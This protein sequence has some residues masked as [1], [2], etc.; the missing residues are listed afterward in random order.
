MLN[1]TQSINGPFIV[2]SLCSWEVGYG[3]SDVVSMFIRHFQRQ[4]ARLKELEG[5]L[6]I[7][8]RIPVHYYGAA[9]C[10]CG[11]ANNID[12]RGRVGS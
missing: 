10:A 4:F 8:V 11:V 3:N 1:S 9:P 6:A 12:A 5:V 7:L 2:G